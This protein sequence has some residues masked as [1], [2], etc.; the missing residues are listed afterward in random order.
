MSRK[1]E[2]EGDSDLF[3]GFYILR[4]LHF[5]H[6]TSANRL[7][8]RPI[9]SRSGDCRPPLGLGR[10]V[11]LSMIST[12]ERLRIISRGQLILTRLHRRRS[13]VVSPGRFG[14]GSGRTLSG[15]ITVAAR[16][17]F[18]LLAGYGIQ[19]GIIGRWTMIMRRGFRMRIVSLWRGLGGV[20][21]SDGHASRAMREF[22]LSSRSRGP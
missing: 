21:R 3:S 5:T 9:P 22:R 19:S 7:A 10:R 12:C 14:P 6:A 20:G 13:L 16:L 2:R 1:K 8:Q 15:D 17:G 11:G 4:Q 18:G